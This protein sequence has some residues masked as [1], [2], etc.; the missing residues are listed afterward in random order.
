[1]QAEMFATIRD[2]YQIERDPNLKLRD[3]PT[4]ADVIRFVHERTPQAAP[5]T[6]VPEAPAA[7]AREP[8]RAAA[9]AG[10]LVAADLAA[11][12]RV[13]RRVP[14][15][16]PRPP[17]E[18][19]VPTGVTLAAGSRVLL[20]GDQGGVGT[21]LSGRL[22][23][24]GV[25]VLPLD[26]TLDAEQARTRIEGWKASGSIQGVYW[27]PALD[28]EPAID[29]LDLDGWREGLRVRVKLLY[30]TMRALGDQ[31][32]GAGTFLVAG[33][34]LGG[35]LGYDEAGATAPMGGAVSGFA[36][37]F[38]RE[39]PDALVKVVDFAPGRKTAQPADRLLAETLHDP[40]TVEIGH[41]DGQR[42]TVGL[43]ER[44]AADGQ[45]GPRLGP[46]S[47]YLVTGAAGSIVSA[48]V[49][50]LAAAGGGGT[51][52]LL[53]LTPAPDPA[54][55]DLRRFAS[56][57]DG[58]KTD[59]AERMRARGER[60][61]PALIERQL[62]G[63]ERGQ[64][65]LSA[66]EAVEAAGGTACWHALDLTDQAAVAAAVAEA[67]T[68]HGRI[69][70]L[71]HA[72]GLE[73][74]RLLAAKEPR[75]FDLVFDVK[76]DGWFNLLRAVGELPLGATVAFSSVAGRF[77]NAGQTDYSAANDLLCKQTSA[78]RRT[79]PATR[80]IAID[81]TAWAGIGMASRGSIPKMMEL[82]GI[83]MLDPAVGIPTVR[84][85]LVAGGGRGEVVVGE[86]L[87]VLTSEWAAAGGLDTEA[88]SALASGP[89]IGRLTG[90][91]VW[92]GLTAETTLDPAAQPFLN[93]HRIDGTAVLPGVM[94]IE[95]FAE[96]AALAL[97]GWRVAAVED[98]RFLAA[99]KFYRDEPRQLLLSGRPRAEGDELVADC[100]LR[101]VRQLAGRP[102][103]Q[104]TTHFTGR[105]RLERA[106]AV[107][108]PAGTPPAPTGTAVE[109][110]DIYR[111]YFHGPAFQVLERAW[112]DGERVVGRLRGD[113]PAGYAPAGASLLM[114]PRLIELAFQTAG[115]RELG[116]SG[117]M[118]L[119]AQVGRVALPRP[120]ERPAG[121]LYAIVGPPSEGGTVDADV[122]DERG[123]VL[124]RM[125]GYGTV[126]LPAG[127][128]PRLLAS[129]RAAMA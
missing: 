30:T 67:G 103:P 107:E 20:A 113:L 120:I 8:E 46:D 97:P 15:A 108:P 2:A 126:E 65:A 121:P 106:A 10:D 105:V 74:S 21:A 111:V 51:F 1:K 86:R 122:V 17:L 76:S 13:P 38:K 128:E 75:E 110:Q 12:D 36:K 50:D 90:M 25:E 99:V 11:A 96:L 40:G 101:T 41:Q 93:D 77:G 27:L 28:P 32:G 49:A 71:V 5:V 69:D 83:D 7:E 123:R 127:P 119:P 89:M 56:D 3:F 117:R 114:A 94:G 52:H 19:C 4:L 60:P 31:V 72:A 125:Q 98:V 70:V 115:I 42:W 26:G 109:R 95:A 129:M 47:V 33:T 79:R 48:I 82:A 102:E 104:V 39:C 124:V 43:T 55:A 68:R 37:A 14:V 61:T 35:R 57:R 53:D 45:P 116:I 54:D 22:A 84:R 64:A 81:W 66:I 63:L 59:L 18:L 62:A 16:V 29:E 91:G 58:L 112:R 34:R 23:K 92:G 87:G 6:A 118:G 80:G 24:L 88:A 100:E 44:P 78:L 73:V 85:E 9:P